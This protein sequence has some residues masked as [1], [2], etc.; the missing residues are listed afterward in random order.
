M[1]NQLVGP[2]TSS[3]RVP[4]Y[5][6]LVIKA[7]QLPKS[8]S[9]HSPHSQESSFSESVPSNHDL[10]GKIGKGFASEIPPSH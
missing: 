4:F 10:E 9:T 5:K 6:K 1:N 8:W 3:S 7:T 2:P